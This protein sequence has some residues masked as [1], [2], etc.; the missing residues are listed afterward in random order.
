MIDGKDLKSLINFTI[1]QSGRIWVDGCFDMGHF[2]HGNLLRQ[3]KE[4]GGIIVCG[5]HSD[6]EIKKHKN[7]APILTE[8]ERYNLVKGFKWV[9][10][11]VKGVPYITTL[12]TLDKYECALA[13]HG[14]DIS[15]A[16]DGSNTYQAIIDAGLYQE[17]PRTQGI[18]T[19][20]LIKR[21]LG[22][23][24]DVSPYTGNS[25]LFS[26]SRIFDYCKGNVRAKDTD[27]IIYVDG[28][29]DLYHPGHVDF[30]RQAKSCG[31]YLI[32]GVHDATV[33][34]LKG[35]ANPYMSLHERAL[36]VLACKYVDEVII[37]A[38]YKVTEELMEYF[39]IDKVYHGMH[40]IELDAY[41]VPMQQEKFFL[42]ESGKQDQYFI[43][44]TSQ[45]RHYKLYL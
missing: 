36:T 3:A 32:V 29:F 27:C 42:I 39:K 41:A 7:R 24:T 1:I 22:D 35:H 26:T 16:K 15:S 11:V 20:K 17:V 23:F 30:L 18:S 10:E 21:V 5:V 28:C 43:H 45:E 44:C 9:D 14:S 4:L 19:T 8:D 31:D 40:N 37:G 2:G 38:P 13:V 12:E 6:E 33:S 34:G 25:L